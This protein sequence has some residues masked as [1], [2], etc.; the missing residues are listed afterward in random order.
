MLYLVSNP[1]LQE[2]RAGS[3]CEP[4][5]QYVFLF[6]SCN[7]KC[8]MPFAAPSPPVLSLLSPCLKVF[9]RL[10][11][12]PLFSIIPSILHHCTHLH[13]ALRS[14]TNKTSR[15]TIISG[16]SGVLQS[17][18]SRVSFCDGSLYDDSL[19]RPFSSRTEPSRLVAH[20]RRNSS[21]L[22]LL[23]ALLDLLRCACVSSFYTLVQFFEVKCNFSTPDV[24]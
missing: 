12:F 17:K 8:V 19:L 10:L 23:G 20:H 7:S 2:G 11:R 22:S 14:R 15:K 3:A 21:V 1:P 13:S 18:H 24:H 5:L 9:L 4:S 16:K 6:P